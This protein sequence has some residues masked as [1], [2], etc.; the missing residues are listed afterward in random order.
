MTKDMES[1]LKR[2]DES[3]V[4][5]GEKIYASDGTDLTLI[6]WMLSLSPAERLEVLQASAESLERLRDVALKDS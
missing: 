6:R 2:R 3:P 5:G 1:Q 4:D